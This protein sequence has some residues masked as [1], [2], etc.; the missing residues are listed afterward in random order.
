M[1]KKSKKEKNDDDFDFSPEV[2]LRAVSLIHICTAPLTKV[3]ESFNLQAIHD[4]L[5]HRA[6]I[7]KYDHLEF[8]GVVPRT[9]IGP[10]VIALFSSPIV[11]PSRMFFSKFA[12]QIIIRICLSEF[13]IRGFQKF[14]ESI[15]K[16][17]GRPF[18]LWLVLIT[19]SQFHLMFYLGRTLPNTLAM[20][21]ALLAIHYWIKGNHKMLILMG[22]IDT[23][24]FRSELAMLFGFIMLF[25]LYHARVTLFSCIKYGIP[26]AILTVGCSV[27][28]DSIFWQR[29]LWPEGEVFWFNTIMNQ[30][31]KWG[32]QPFL[33]YFYSALPRAMA[34]SVLLV[35]YGFFLP[36]K[37]LRFIFYVIPVF[38]VAAAATCDRLWKNRGK[39]F[40]HALISV[41]VI[42]HLVVNGVF[43]TGMLIVSSKNYPGGNALLKLHQVESLDSKLNLHIDVYSAQTGISRFMELSPNWRY[44]KSEIIVPGSEEMMEFTHLIVGAEDIQSRYMYYKTHETII[45]VEGYSGIDM[46]LNRF[47]PIRIKT[48]TL[49]LVLR[50]LPKSAPAE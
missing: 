46:N 48:E 15:S 39:S 16:E 41:G 26:V 18:A 32:T 6:D 1:G 13:V 8:P 31:H 14:R 2:I 12:A 34:T 42:F 10:L 11:T 33:W 19:A 25:E 40:V 27:L 30:S 36:H 35:P 47:P 49:V 3:E 28:V 29:L 45:S 22:G 17:F 43:S 4:I 37:E 44:N 9:F 20:P 7:Q 5:F 24:I 23:I 50:K 38:N 21:A